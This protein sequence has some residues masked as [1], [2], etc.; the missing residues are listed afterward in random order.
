[1]KIQFFKGKNEEDLC[2]QINLFS[3][4]KIVDDVY[5]VDKFSAYVTF[6]DDGKDD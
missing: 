6:Y 2:F 5:L 1:M 4:E 3:R